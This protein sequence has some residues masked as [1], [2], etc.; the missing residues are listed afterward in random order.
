[1]KSYR[2]RAPIL[3]TGAAIAVGGCAT[4]GP[5]TERAATAIAQPVCSASTVV[6]RE[7]GGAE[8]GADVSTLLGYANEVRAQ[9][10]ALQR[11]EI[12]RAEQALVHGH[13]A[14]E[15]LRLGLLL[16]LPET[17][18]RDVG[19]SRR[20]LQQL[21]KDGAPEEQKGLSEILLVLLNERDAQEQA[22]R[23]IAQQWEDEQRK[24]ET[25]Q[26]QLKA[27]KAIEETIIE[28]GRPESLQL[29]DVDQAE[30]PAS[31]R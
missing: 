20:L 14:S 3:L 19:R 17:G 5:G 31:R 2:G 13:G 22:R 28:R 21:M 18:F 23:S 11:R 30:N 7:D 12:R 29:D 25:L 27:L 10:E 9:P 1:M 6:D 26:R 24:R 15:R 16:L 8:A 4:P